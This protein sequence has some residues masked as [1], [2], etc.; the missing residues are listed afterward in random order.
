MRQI[1]PLL[2]V[3]LLLPVALLAGD[4]GGRD[5]AA[6]YE[7]GAMVVGDD[8]TATIV[9]LTGEDVIAHGAHTA[10]DAVR[11]AAGAFVAGNLRWPE[12]GERYAS[13]NG[14]D[15]TQVRVFVDGLPVNHALYGTV[16]LEALPADQIAR[17]RIYRGPAPLE[18]G[19]EGGAVI[20]IVTREAG[21]KFT[22]RFDARF[23]DHRTNYFSV[24][25]GDT[26]EWF[27]YFAMASHDSADGW[28]MP[29]RFDL[30]NNEDG[31]IRELS[32]YSRN[33]LRA[34][35]GVHFAP[36]AQ[37]HATFFYDNADREIPHN[38]YTGRQRY[39]RVPEDTR[40]GGLLHASLGAFGPFS[41]RLTGCLSATDEER[42]EF[43]TPEDEM[44]RSQVNVLTQRTGAALLPTLDLGRWSKLT[45]R[46]GLVHDEIEFEIFDDYRDRT[47]INQLDFSL[48]DRLNPIDRLHLNLG[49]G[50]GRRTIAAA[51]NFAEPDPLSSWFGRVAVAGGPF[52]GVTLRA[53]GG[54]SLR[55]PTVEE[56][57]DRTAGNPALETALI[58][59]VDGSVQ[60]ALPGE[61]TLALTGFYRH[62]TDLPRLSPPIAGEPRFYF[63]DDAE[64]T[65]TGLTLSAATAPLDGLYL[66]A[67]YTLQQVNLSVEG[68][69]DE[70][71]EYLPEHLGGGE[72]RYRF[73]FGLGATV[74]TD[75]VGERHE[76]YRGQ[77]L[78]IPWYMTVGAR[79]FYAYRNRI[80]VYAHGQNLTDVYYETK[81][82]YPEPGR[83]LEAGLKLT[84]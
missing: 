21:R 43:A 31:G 34:R 72:A 60:A 80:E 11:Y 78:T 3:F 79:M 22:G 53:A 47:L 23:G 30:T 73:P 18:F 29:L 66:G 7:L 70:Q 2:L 9:E 8:P 24:G 37:T 75:Y 25:A 39:Y 41:L 12:R 32:A 19:G 14:A 64:E 40:M 51:R 35:A 54:R 81:A 59:A 1:A 42:N 5:Y 44:E 17:L 28:P 26:A 62:T 50:Y 58:D 57:F 82:F 20:E 76:W 55:F 27:Q 63:V 33:Q 67:H 15:P 52:A 84:Y 49:G 77:D 45:A 69:D 83:R 68:E 48:T 38:V 61:T 16:D 13:I 4:E 71:P 46:A 56:S 6:P 65:A 36:Q 74:F 10:A